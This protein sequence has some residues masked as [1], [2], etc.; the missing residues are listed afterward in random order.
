ML[1]TLFLLKLIECFSP[2]CYFFT[3][4]YRIQEKKNLDLL[5]HHINLDVIYK[6]K[7]SWCYVRDKEKNLS[8]IT[9]ELQDL[10]FSENTEISVL[11]L[12]E[13]T[14]GIRFC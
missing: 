13:K 7:G 9:L 3:A 12:I 11:F 10:A 4:I 1:Q 14:E 2:S 6:I 5:L 8:V